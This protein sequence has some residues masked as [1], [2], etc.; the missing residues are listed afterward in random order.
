M[1]PRAVRTWY[2]Y[3]YLRCLASSR[4]SRGLEL[5]R[6]RCAAPCRRRGGRRWSNRQAVMNS[7]TM[8]LTMA[9]TGQA[10]NNTPPQHGGGVGIGVM[11]VN[12]TQ[13]MN[14]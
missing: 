2:K 12:Y 11:L 14:L 10:H 7:W 9:A 4:V 6:C 3:R 1:S 8:M 5:D 13:D